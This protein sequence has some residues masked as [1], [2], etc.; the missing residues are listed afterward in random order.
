MQIIKRQKLNILA[1]EFLVQ[2]TGKKNNVKK[3]GCFSVLS[4]NLGD[5]IQSEIGPCKNK[6][7]CPVCGTI[8]DIEDKKIEEA[9]DKYLETTESNLEAIK[10]FILITDQ[11]PIPKSD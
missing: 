2:C 9:I 7:Q 4:I 5:V 10:K 3:L 8:S 11:F 6:F 1:V